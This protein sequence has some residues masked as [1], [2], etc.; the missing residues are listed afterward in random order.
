MEDPATEGEVLADEDEFDAGGGL[1]CGGGEEGGTAFRR[2][3]RDSGATR[4]G[5]AASSTPLMPNHEPP[6]IV[7]AATAQAV[8]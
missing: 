8:R 5:T 2:S 4:A 1:G 7:A 6:T 3:V